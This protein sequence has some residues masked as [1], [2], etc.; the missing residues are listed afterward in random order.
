MPDGLYFGMSMAKAKSYLRLS[1]AR[2]TRTHLTGH[3]V[4]ALGQFQFY[5]LAAKKV[6][7]FS[8]YMSIIVE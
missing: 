2:Q 8:F 7:D 1:F 5:H 4:V 3:V 6:L